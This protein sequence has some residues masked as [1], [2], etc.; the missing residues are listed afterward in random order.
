MIQHSRSQGIEIRDSSGRVLPER[1]FPR[2]RPPMNNILFRKTKISRT[3]N[4]GTS[5]WRRG[6]T[7]SSGY[8]FDEFDEFDE[9]DIDQQ[10]YCAFV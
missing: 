6:F 1:V 3:S 4:F 9:F 8:S 5:T 2:P 10:L 7:F